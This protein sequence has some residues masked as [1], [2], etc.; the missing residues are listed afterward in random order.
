MAKAVRELLKN[1]VEY[2]TGEEQVIWKVFG[3]DDSYSMEV[4]NEG[5]LASDMDADFFE[6]WSRGD[7]SRTSGGSG[8]GLPIAATIMQ[9]HNGSISITQAD[10]NLVKASVKWPK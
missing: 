3:T 9:L 2:G 10:E 6:P 4:I 8:L 7:W 1:A 5:H